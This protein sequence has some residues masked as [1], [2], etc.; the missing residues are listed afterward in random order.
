MAPRFALYTAPA[1]DDPLHDWAAEWLGRDPESGENFPPAPAGGLSSSRVAELTAD[2]RL[3]GFHGTLKPPFRLADGCDEAQLI[4]AL[5]TFTAARAPVKG[6][7]LKAAALG[8]FLALRPS[9]PHQALEALAADCV[10]EFDRFRAPLSETELAKRRKSALTDRQEQYLQ[11]WGYP[12]VLEE[13]RLHFTLTGPIRDEA[14]RSAL[15]QYLATETAPLTKND[16]VAE[17]LCLFVQPQP[18]EA[19]RIAGRYRFG[20]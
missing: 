3:Y 17:E 1:V 11:T 8:S 4:M 2:P 14:E 20:G 7:P 9:A 5:E 15:L 12:Y 16:Y 19:F 6:P 18:G 13:F 10:T